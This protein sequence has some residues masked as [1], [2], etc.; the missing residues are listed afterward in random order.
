MARAPKPVQLKKKSPIA[1]SKNPKKNKS[2]T[3]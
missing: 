1:K 3:A 2:G